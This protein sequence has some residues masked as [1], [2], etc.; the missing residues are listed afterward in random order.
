M[1]RL[2][3]FVAMLMLRALLFVSMAPALQAQT[4]TTFDPPDSTS[5]MASAIN[6]RGQVT[7]FYL[8]G[9]G[10][11]HGFLRNRDAT[12]IT[13]DVL[14]GAPPNASPMD[15]NS[16]GTIVGSYD[17]FIDTDSFLRNPDGTV[18]PFFPTLQDEAS[19]PKLPLNNCVP[20][21]KAVAINT[22]GQITGEFQA[23]AC[24]GFLRQ[25][26]ST[27]ITFSV[28]S[29]SHH[30]YI[31]EA[32]PQAINLFA[33]ITG[34]YAEYGVVIQYGGFLRQPSGR[35]FRF[36]APSSTITI[37]TSINLFGQI[38]GYYQDT[39]SVEHGFLRKPNGTMITFD[40]AGSTDTEAYSINLLGEITGFY[41]GADGLHHGFLRKCDGTFTTFDVPGSQG[42]FA[43]SINLAG[44]ITG[45]YFD[46]STYHGFIRSGR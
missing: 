24:Y 1:T 29:V 9:T 5:T 41:L 45:Y 6:L 21:S 40:P 16:A 18:I 3:S 14:A 13:F 19:T 25:P 36:F 17:N 4:I 8:A 43:K 42:T 23:Q 30:N 20:G 39:N 46:G 10:E 26:D 38:T 28:P 31:P 11:A 44:E 27:I 35:M 34:Y 12:F 33:Q 22:V 7:G 15:I 37:P 2:L 32:H